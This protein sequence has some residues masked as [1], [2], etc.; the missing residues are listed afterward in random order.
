MAWLSVERSGPVVQVG[1]LGP[2]RLQKSLPEGEGTLVADGCGEA[3]CEAGSVAKPM[4]RAAVADTEVPVSDSE[5]WGHVQTLGQ[6]G[7]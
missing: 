7:P 5:R 3:D 6:Q 2:G 4:G 1:T